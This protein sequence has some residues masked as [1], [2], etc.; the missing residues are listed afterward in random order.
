[1]EVI[2]PILIYLIAP[3][4]GLSAFVRL[5]DQMR[6]SLIEDPPIIPL[7]IIFA[8]YGGWLMIALTLRFWYWSGMALIGFIYLLYGAPLLMTALAVIL[9]RQR[10]ISGYHF[11]SFVASGIYPCII[12]VI[13]LA[14]AFR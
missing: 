4:A 5:K 8:T 2:T 3:L 7:F 1:M 6:K 11:G 12:A 13:I 10:R 14:R 9:Y